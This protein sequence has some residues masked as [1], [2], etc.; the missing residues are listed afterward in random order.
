MTNAREK[1]VARGAPKGKERVEVGG[2]AST[3]IQEE[4]VVEGAKACSEGKTD[5][6]H[7]GGTSR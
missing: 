5:Q 1:K 7:R 2:K 3:W 6:E 4:I